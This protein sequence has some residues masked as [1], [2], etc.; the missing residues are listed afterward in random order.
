MKTGAAP[1]ILIDN[2]E[3]INR[4]Q[5]PNGNPGF[6]QNLP[7]CGFLQCFTDFH[8]APW[9]RPQVFC[10]RLAPPNQEN[11]VIFEYYCT[12][13]NTGLSG[14]RAIGAGCEFLQCLV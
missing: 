1:C 9:N 5:G 13:G 14:I 10:R 12:D 11:F 3:S 8:P 7:L 6:F 4:F 2:V